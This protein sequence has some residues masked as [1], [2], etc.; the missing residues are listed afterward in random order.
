MRDLVVVSDLHIGR[1]RNPETGRFHSLEN[2][3]YDEDFLQFCRY[4]THEAKERGRPLT[5]V[6]NGDTFDFLRV[7][8]VEASQR[9]GGQE[10]PGPTLTPEIAAEMV[11]RMLAGH[12]TFLD[13]IAHLLDEGHRVV[14][15]PGN[16]DIELQ[17][18]EVQA[19]IRR[20]I[21]ERSST[22]DS[23]GL[24]FHPWFFY[25]PGRIWI[26]HGCQYDAEC[27]FRF[28]LRGA[29]D[30]ASVRALDG[31]M[32]LGNFFQRYL[33]NAFGPITF[34]VPST[35]ANF[36]YFRW[37]LSNRPRLLAGVLVR[38][39]VFSLKLLRR[40]SQN[41]ANDPGVE[42]AHRHELERLAEGSGLGPKLHAIERFKTVPPN[43]ALASRA[44][45]LPL[46]RLT[47]GVASGAL[48]L[49]AL[50]FWSFQA[51]AQLQVASG[52]RTLLFLIIQLLLL[53]VVVS[54]AVW[55]ALQSRPDVPPRPLRRAAQ[56]ISNLL[57]VPLVTFGHTHDEAIWRLPNGQGEPG[58]YF[59]TGTWI[60]VFT[61]EE[62]VPRERVQLTFLRVRDA[63]GELLQWSPGRGAPAPVV[64]L[65]EGRPAI[66]EI[67][68]AA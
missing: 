47:I 4:L 61:H 66:R 30:R 65:D 29:T 25:E 24:E 5:L 52:F 59:N 39:G 33:Y 15:L 35:R 37:L 32:P 18:P 40:L 19:E 56:R 48:A 36:R 16:H 8:P 26:E 31:D 50:W 68:R 49:A 1:G 34:I 6:F 17:W 63:K 42:A 11:R 53:I 7:D 38:N 2:F 45:L 3:F 62:L 10:R 28:Q 44:F 23:P 9:V 58:W 54:G 46:I 60:A 22:W 43:L 21:L 14:F 12:P 51:I 67:P 27:A 57:K 64:L 55:V 20:A 41:A 13:G